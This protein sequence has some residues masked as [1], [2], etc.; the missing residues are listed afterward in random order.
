MHAVVAVEDTQSESNVRLCLAASAFF[1]GTFW[2]GNCKCSF[3]LPNLQCHFFAPCISVPVQYAPTCT[4]RG[5]DVKLGNKG[6]TMCE[7]R[8]ISSVAFCKSDVISK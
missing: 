2:G 7:E 1:A 3:I 8:I 5:Q 4:C 6:L